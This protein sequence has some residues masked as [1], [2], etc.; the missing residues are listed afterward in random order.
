MNDHVPSL[1]RLA[2]LAKQR[3]GY[4]AR[5]LEIY[6]KHEGVD[7]QQLAS[8]LGGEV[9]ALP[10]LALCQRPRPTPHFRDDIDRI[11][12]Y[13]HVQPLALARMIRSAEAMEQSQQ[14]E[15][16]TFFLAAR[17]YHEEIVHHEE[18][19]ELDE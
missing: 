7:D 12:G 10:L 17:D 13:V 8:L 2:S 9:S 16:K 15:A 6:Q 5:L 19:E 3:Q 14:N 18:H 11:A 1:A 4:L